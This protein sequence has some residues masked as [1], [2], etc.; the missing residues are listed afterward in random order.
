MKPISDRTL[1]QLLKR[2]LV[3]L[4]LFHLF[5]RKLGPRQPVHVSAHGFTDAGEVFHVHGTADS[6]DDALLELFAAAESG[7][8]QTFAASPP[9]RA[10]QTRAPSKP[11]TERVRSSLS[12]AELRANRRRVALEIAER[13]GIVSLDRLLDAF[14]IVA[15]V[16]TDRDPR[17]QEFAVVL[18]ELAA[19]GRLRL[20]PGGFA[21]VGE[22]A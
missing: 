3:E 10:R 17:R 13:V 19:D 1:A 6:L 14:G 21:L 7:R 9:P 2:R 12:G 22:D 5:A 4:K 11:E 20:V 16:P 18:D 15:I 8:A